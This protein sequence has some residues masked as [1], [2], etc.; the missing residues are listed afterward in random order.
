VDRGAGF[1]DPPL[2]RI[3]GHRGLALDAP[4]N[5]PLAFEAALKA[6]ASHI[7]TDVHA[8]LDGVAV[9]S[10]DPD[11]SRLL[12]RAVRVD[13]LTM[14]ELA[15]ID[16]GKG[17]SFVSLADG[18]R[19]FPGVRFNI[20]IK[21]ESAERPAAE[22]ILAAG[23]VSRVLITSFD[24]GRRSRTVSALPGVASSASASRILLAVVGAKLGIRAIVRHALRGL[25]AVQVPERSGLIHVVTPRVIRA[26]HAAGLEFHVWTIN[27]PDDM[28]RL[29]DLG[30]DGLVT[31]RCDLARA[32]VDSRS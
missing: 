7:E 16:L 22:S 12:G 11:L 2:P 23:A 9:I 21:T 26:V 31:D 3:F 29:L 5:T 20:D 27:D 13:E 8:S 30:V 15:L 32:I 17:Q 19:L 18:L 1:F 4:E 24:E 14:A 10:H 6:G 28:K 25:N